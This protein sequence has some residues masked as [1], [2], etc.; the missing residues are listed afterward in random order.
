MSIFPW[1]VLILQVSHPMAL[2]AQN[3]SQLTEVWAFFQHLGRGSIRLSSLHS[4][5]GDIWAPPAAQPPF[6]LSYKLSW[7]LQSSETT[8]RWFPILVVASKH[9]LSWHLGQKI[10]HLSDTMS[11]DSLRVSERPWVHC[12]REEAAEQL[13]VFSAFVGRNESLAIWVI[14]EKSFLSCSG[15]INT[16]TVVL[17]VQ[18]VP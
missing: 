18:A 17:A 2:L 16:F 13:Q 11:L 10:S 7:I 1:V 15:C 4:Y 8:C 5:A 12:A 6:F 3:H 9:W 14:W